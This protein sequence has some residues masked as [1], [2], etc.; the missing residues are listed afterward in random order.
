MPIRI[1]PGKAIK[2]EVKEGESIKISTPFGGQGCDL[3]FLEFDQALTR[4]ING[5]FGYSSLIADI[6]TKLYDCHG[7]NILTITKKN[8]NS[9][10]DIIFPGCFS[11]LYED[12]RKGCRDVLS[13]VLGVKRWH[14]PAVVS[15]FVDTQIINKSKIKFKP[16]SAKAG[17]YITIKA[18]K[19]VDL[20]ISC[21]PDDE[22]CFPNPSEIVIEKLD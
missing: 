14:L 8:T 20:A 1:K 9:S 3:V 7:N 19:Q 5:G 11:E 18:M 6:G 15:L 4:N 12:R 21:C 22:V 10:I 2:I 16:S 13:E 17:D